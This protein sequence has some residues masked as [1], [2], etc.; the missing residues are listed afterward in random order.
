MAQ[1]R[2]SWED[3]EDSLP[4]I[5]K[6]LQDACSVGSLVPWTIFRYLMKAR[7]ISELAWTSTI[8]LTASPNQ[9]ANQN[10]MGMKF[11]RQRFFM[12]LCDPLDALARR[13]VGKQHQPPL[14]LRWSVGAP[15]I[16]ESAATEYI[17]HLRLLA[18]LKPSSSIL[19]IGCGCGQ[20][21]LP[22]MDFLDD[23][24][25][26][27]GWDLMEDVIDWCKRSIA[28][29]DK[30]FRFR[31]IDVMNGMYNPSGRSSPAE[32]VFTH[33]REYDVILLKS[34]F[35]HMFAPETA[36]YLRQISE[37]LNEDGK[38]LATFFLLNPHQRE[39]VQKGGSSLSFEHPANGA[40]MDNPTV[41]EAAVGYEED[42]LQN[43][44]K[45]ANLRLSKPPFYGNW[46][47]DKNALSYQDILILEK[48][49]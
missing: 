17:L 30:R 45:A 41:P 23:S 2:S 49:K 44:L 14:H 24:G 16:W 22:L 38:C 35:T 1:V 6:Q 32:F 13:I 28:A 25:T 37:L 9:K 4:K 8:S 39:I 26:Y 46:T 27:E 48:A 21:A 40:F 29:R 7:P 10:T 36:N 18:G 42:Q 11:G 3:A 34:V 31:H 33:D 47:G 20:V 12:Y 19:D 5:R 43:M 15:A